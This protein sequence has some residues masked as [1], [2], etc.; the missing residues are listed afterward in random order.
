MVVT[1]LSQ[2]EPDSNVV[3]I[4]AKQPISERI[5][6]LPEDGGLW[7]SIVVYDD[8]AKS[9]DSRAVASWFATTPRLQ[10]LQAQTKHFAWPASHWW[11]K[12]YRPRTP[13]PF[14]LLLDER[15]K[16]VYE[17][18]RGQLPPDGEA[19]ADE[20]EQQITQCCPD[21]VQ[22][23]KPRP[24]WQAEGVIPLRRPQTTNQQSSLVM[25]LAFLAVSAAA[26]AMLARR[27]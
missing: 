5:I 14:V 25:I 9:A 6:D 24:D 21:E 18:Y 16:P 11:V 2:P 26:G 1:A 15:H 13:V 27:T 12:Q 20:V 8:G 17:A 23:K 3:L 19:L 10:S 7:T 22:P 4:E